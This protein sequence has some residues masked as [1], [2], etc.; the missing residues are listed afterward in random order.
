MYYFL[1]DVEIFRA[2]YETIFHMLKHLKGHY[3]RKKIK[4]PA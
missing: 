2:N 1:K 4:L 3:F